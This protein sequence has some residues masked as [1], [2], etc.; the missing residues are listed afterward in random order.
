ML[1]IYEVILEVLRMLVPV[2]KAIEVHDRG[3]A[4]QLKEASQSIALNTAEGSGSR[5]GTRRARY[6]TASG[7]AQETGGCLDTA[8]SM[9]YVESVDSELL[10]KLD[11]V[12]AVLWKL[13]R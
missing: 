11:H 9:A 3:L 8:L 2:I 13:S 12:R 4:G 7:S 6:E 5:G 10:N 1:R